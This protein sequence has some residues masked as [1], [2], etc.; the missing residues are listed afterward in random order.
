[1]VLAAQT[2]AGCWATADMPIESEVSEVVYGFCMKMETFDFKFKNL[3]PIN[4]D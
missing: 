1:M 4:I 3:R 2:I